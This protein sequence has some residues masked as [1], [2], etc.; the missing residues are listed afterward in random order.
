MYQYVLCLIPKARWHAM[1][2]L[3][4]RSPRHQSIVLRRHAAHEPE[5]F[6]VNSLA[7][8]FFGDF[9]GLS[10]EKPYING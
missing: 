1:E 8:L 7:A 4:E 2:D 10:G 5:S 9:L 3:D 6:G